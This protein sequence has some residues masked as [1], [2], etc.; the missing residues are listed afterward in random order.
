MILGTNLIS[1]LY[2]SPPLKLHQTANSVCKENHCWGWCWIKGS[3]KNESR[4][5]IQIKFGQQEV[6]FQ[7]RPKPAME[8]KIYIIKLT[9][10]ERWKEDYGGDRPRVF[11]IKDLWKALWGEL[12]RSDRGWM[13]VERPDPQ[14]E[15][16]GLA[17]KLQ[18]TEAWSPWKFESVVNQLMR[19]VSRLSIVRYTHWFF[20]QVV[21]PI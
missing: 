8:Q 13:W 20:L 11:M 14:S 6:I 12:R 4:F 3:G 5:N 1:C 10:T 15:I 19:L 16:D 7:S 9:G 18:G 17:G 2:L 21:Q